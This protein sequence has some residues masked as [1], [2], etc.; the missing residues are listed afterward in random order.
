LG[1]I[2][3]V[4]LG[5]HDVAYAAQFHR[6]ASRK[7][8][9]AA[10]AAYGKGKTTGDVAQILEAKYHLIEKFYE[11]NRDIIADAVK[12]SI[13]GAITNIMAGQPGHVVLTA[14]AVSDIE[15]RF[16]HSLSLRAYD[17]VI[18]GVPTKASLAGVSHRFAKPYAKRPSRPSFIDTGVFQVHF[19]AWVEVGAAA[20]VTHPMTVQ[21]AA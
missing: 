12:E 8:A 21:F 17:G 1:D 15:T 13:S 18:A 9:S 19:A 6:W 2:V 5:V 16:K 4:Q 3:I 14:Q 20:Q 10:Q 7:R 11:L